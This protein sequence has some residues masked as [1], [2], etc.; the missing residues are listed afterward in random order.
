MKRLAYIFAAALMMFSCQKH[1]ADNLVTVNFTVK[2]QGFQTEI[3]TKGIADGSAATQLLVGVFDTD[4]N[5]IEG[6]KTVVTGTSGNFEFSLQ[7]VESLTYKVVLFAQSPDKF[8]NTASWTA[9]GLKTISLAGKLA[10]N[11]EAC[12][13]FSAVTTVTPATSHTVEVNLTR[14]FAQVNVATTASLSGITTATLAISGVPSVFNAYTAEATGSQNLSLSATPLNTAFAT[15]YTYIL[16]A[17]VPVTG[18]HASV[19]ATVT[20]DGSDPKTVQN[21]PLQRNYRTNI[22][23][24]I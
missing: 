24:N 16:Y 8:V 1:D 17:Y 18:A 10:A 14:I 19:T 23:G 4:G 12:D 13:A 15:G 20:L 22:L 6:Y 7:L 9:E 5:A 11:S 3:G 21:V 2:Q